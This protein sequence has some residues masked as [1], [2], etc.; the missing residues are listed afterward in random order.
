M[1]KIIISLAV[2]I[3][4]FIAPQAFAEEPTLAGEVSIKGL[5]ANV[6]GSEAK[7]NEYRDLDDG[8]YGHIK[9]LYDTDAWWLKANVSDVGYDTQKYQLDGGMWGLFKA[10]LF[11]RE[12]PHNITF[13]ARSMFTGVGTGNLTLAGTPGDSATWPSFFDYSTER[14]QT[15]G[16][17]S[18]DVLKPF[19]FNV[20]AMTEHRKGNKPA[21]AASFFDVVATELPEPVDYRTNTI[22]A[23]LGYA[24][25]PIFLDVYFMY[26]DF[27]NKNDVLNFTNPVSLAADALTLPPDNKYYKAGFKGAVKLP[28]NTKLNLNAG[29]SETTD[30][31]SLLTSD[32]VFGSIFPA[33]NFNGKVA[34]QNVDLVLTTNPV[35][36]LDGKV[37]YKYYNKDNKSDVV[38]QTDQF[39]TT[40]VNRL[41]DYKKN[42]F[43]GELGFRLPMK[44]YLSAGYTRVVTDR[45]LDTLAD[46]HDDIYSAEFRW[47]GIDIMTVRAGY[48]RLVRN[49]DFHVPADISNVDGARN[50]D[51][52]DKTRDSIK[53]SVDLYPVDFLSVGVG[54]KHKETSYKKLQFGL[55]SDRGDEVFTNADLMIGNYAQLFGYFDYQQTRRNTDQCDTVF[56]ACSDD[57]KWNL[58]DKETYY[59]FGAGTNI[60]LMPKKLTLRFQYDYSRSN[61]NADLTLGNTLFTGLGTVLPPNAN[62]NNIDIPNWDDYTKQSFMAKFIYDVTKHIALS[63]GYAYE[64]FKYSDAQL[65]G[66][67]LIP[68]DAGAFLTGAYS[69]QSYKA[70]LYFA[71]MTYKFW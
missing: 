25:K 40:Y 47:K 28:Y 15:G 19:F 71:T 34:T 35:N 5:L 42:Q 54:Y 18:L 67:A 21:G 63:V 45:P 11:Y 57:T 12:I 32:G 43:G 64:K 53:F 37:F 16:S 69:N 61:G 3:S 48:E 55:K 39:L 29:W 65:D 50:F 13:G 51:L 60:F 2:A 46:T 52:A 41:F 14:R 1:K 4:S 22:K 44:S 58:K 62:Q 8:I 33:G 66:Y 20:S 7:F 59:D 31:V 27:D 70:N 68:S 26:S 23:D 56:G 49:S 6:K 9:L 30:H 24:K 36:F 10:D 17:F 38:S